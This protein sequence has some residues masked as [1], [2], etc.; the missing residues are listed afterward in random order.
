VEAEG[1]AVDPGLLPSS[2]VVEVVAVHL[3]LVAAAEAAEVVFDRACCV[4]K[5]CPCT[6]SPMNIN[7]LRYATLPYPSGAQHTHTHTHMHALQIAT[8]QGPS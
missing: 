1:A 3:L 4:P 7:A 5:R 2:A 8:A 6:N